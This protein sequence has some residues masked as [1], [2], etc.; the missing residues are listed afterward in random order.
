MNID[1]KMKWIIGD[2]QEGI[3]IIDK[4]FKIL[5][6]NKTVN[7]IFGLERN[8]SEKLKVQDLTII[9]CEDLTSK[10]DLNDKKQIRF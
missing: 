4:A 5:Y 8:N 6:K 2:L 1:Q 10:A 7:K 3:I 9:Q